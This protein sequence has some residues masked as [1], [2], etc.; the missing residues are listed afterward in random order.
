M[1]AEILH[2]DFIKNDT[3]LTRRQ[4]RYQKNRDK[5]LDQRKKYYE[6][7]KEKAKA[8]YKQ[9]KGKIAEN[10]QANRDKILSSTK[11]WKKNN[12]D[13][14]SNYH[15]TRRARKRNAEGSHTAA[16]IQQLLVFQKRKCAVCHT[17]I[18][19]NYHV[20]HVIPLALGG[21]NGKD[22]LQLLCPHCNLRKNAQHPVEFMQSRGMLL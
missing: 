7:N 8:Y 1:T 14:T 22:N 9:N 4:T 15:R 11:V 19:N 17:S 5:I 6:S 12:R 18:K 21:G 16:N 3:V 20:D 10:Y 2:E 13:K